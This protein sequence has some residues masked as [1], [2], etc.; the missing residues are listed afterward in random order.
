MFIHWR[1]FVKVHDSQ[2]GVGDDPAARGWRG[3][4]GESAVLQ[5]VT[6]CLLPLY[7]RIYQPIKDKHSMMSVL[8]TKTVL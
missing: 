7:S 8:E 2:D 4:Q 5:L 1:R 3:D 6:H